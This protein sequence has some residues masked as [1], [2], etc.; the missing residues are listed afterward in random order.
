[1]DVG[2]VSRT[3]SLLR[4]YDPEFKIFGAEK[5]RY[6]LLPTAAETDVATFEALI[7]VALPPDYRTFVT[8]LGDGGAG[9]YYGML[10]L[11]PGADPK[12]DFGFEWE[13]YDEP[14]PRLSRPFQF[15]QAWDPPDDDDEWDRAVPPGC[16]V[17]DGLVVVADQGCNYWSHLVVNGPGAGQIWGDYTCV[18]E[19]LCP[20]AESFGAWYQDWLEVSLREAL[21]NRIESTVRDQTGWTVDE[22]LL[23]AMPPLL[24]AGDDLEPGVRV[25]RLLRPTYLALYER[26]HDDARR[27]LTTAR[28]VP[29]GDGFSAHAKLAVA[30]AV[31]LREEG[32][33]GPALAAVE[34][35]LLRGAWAD[36][37]ALLRRLQAELL[38]S[39]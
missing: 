6:R 4:E 33:L 26:R 10:P 14:R 32:H 2:G 18:G 17:Y 23:R 1:V 30:E 24:P 35:A 38:L 25:L 39:R 11:R 28:E 13:P 15:T 16:N 7:G 8:Q 5:H 20:E 29:L 31:L 19:A 21:F 34:N 22:R 27:I 9:P 12:N 36:D 3:L 37:E